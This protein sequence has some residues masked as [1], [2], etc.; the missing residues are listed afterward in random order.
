[1][2]KLRENLQRL[3]YGRYG[4]DAFGQFLFG[5]V[6]GIIVLNIVIRSPWLSYIELLMVIYGYYRMM[7]KNH[8]RRYQENRK[9]LEIKNK[10]FGI[11]Q[12]ERRLMEERKVNHI[13]ACPS[14]KQKIRVP[15]GKGK[16]EI[17]CPKCHTKFVKR[18]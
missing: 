13:Y 10:I 8:Q 12:R 9:F 17:T 15:K 4:V 11:F 2:N 7:S 18:S 16:I 14:C 6:L 1:M 3:L 5:V